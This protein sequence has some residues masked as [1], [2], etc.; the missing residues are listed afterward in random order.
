[1]LNITIDI[2]G[3]PSI[4]SIT[5][6]NQHENRDEEILFTF[7]SEFAN[8]NKYV[9]A[10]TYRKDTKENINR[11]LIVNNNKVVITSQL[12]SIPGIWH[13][14]TVC[15]SY[16]I[17]ETADYVNLTPQEGE[18]ISISDA[19]IARVNANDIDVEQIANVQVDENI[20]ILYDDI[21]SL[22]LRVEKNEATRQ[23]Q[24]NTRQTT[25][26]NRADAES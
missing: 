15:K 23:S 7:P 6:G 5:I 25:E 16:P 2:N 20:K 18:R 3:A 13:L 22:K 8:Y 24:E 26:A 1:M 12:T 11:L 10:R 14:Y 9:V 17:D 21:L 4:N 19:I